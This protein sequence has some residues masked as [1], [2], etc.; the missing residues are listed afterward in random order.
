MHQPLESFKTPKPIN[1]AYME[2]NTHRADDIGEL[3]LFRFDPRDEHE[4]RAGIHMKGDLYTVAC[5]AAVD[6]AL[7]TF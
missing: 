4:N 5:N 7:P 1:L 2:Q 6:Y 3:G